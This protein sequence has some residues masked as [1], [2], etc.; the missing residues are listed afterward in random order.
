MANNLTAFEQWKSRPADERYWDIAELRTAADNVRRNCVEKEGIPLS[1]CHAQVQGNGLELTGPN[2]AP[3]A[4]THFSFS[5]VC[6]SLSIPAEY[7]RSVSPQ[8]AAANLN[9]RF[10]SVQKDPVTALLQ[11]RADQPNALRSFTSKRYARVWNSEVLEFVADLESRG[12]RVPPAR[13]AGIANERTR[14]ATM[15]DVLEAGSH[16]DLSVKVGDLV[17]PA[18]LYMNDRSMFTF[19]V[20]VQQPIDVEGVRG[21]RGVY[22][23]NSEV[24][25]A[26]LGMR[27]FFFNS[28]CGNHIVWG[29]KLYREI[30]LRH[31]GEVSRRFD[32]ARYEITTAANQSVELEVKQITA[33]RRQVIADTKEQVV[34]LVYDRLRGLWSQKTVD[35]IYDTADQWAHI[36][37]PANTVWGMVSGATRYSQLLPCDER[38]LMDQQAGRLLAMAN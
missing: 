5:Q 18:G 3:V 37:G 35:A 13:P 11:R 8:L 25:D 16:P 36:H 28:V 24:G 21:F 17:A 4:F 31:I 12:W 32:N 23:W 22:I 38:D 20:N 34:E 2:G 9:E 19:L 1:Q 7:I 14:I 33:A 29:E 15:A 27:M 26:T 30:R 10:H 6:K